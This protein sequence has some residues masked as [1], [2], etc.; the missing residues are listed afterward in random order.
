MS[1]GAICLVMYNGSVACGGKNFQGHLSTGMPDSSIKPH[2]P[3]ATLA[4][5]TV[6]SMAIAEGVACV[7]AAP[8]QGNMVYCLGV[9]ARGQLGDGK[10]KTNSVVPMPVLGLRQSP[11][12]AQLVVSKTAAC[13]LYAGPGSKSSVQCWGSRL[14]DPTPVSQAVDV[15]GVSGAASLA[16]GLSTACAVLNTGTVSC[17]RYALPMAAAEVPNLGNVVRL[18]ISDGQI[19]H[20]AIVRSVG[21]LGSLWCW[22]RDY[23]GAVIDSSTP[24]RVSGLP[25]N[26]TDVALGGAHACALV[27]NSSDGSGGD[28]FCWG[29]NDYGQLG[30]GYANETQGFAGPKFTVPMRVKGLS[31]T[32]A[33][34]R[35]NYHTCAVTT[36]RQ[37]LCWGDNTFGQ[38]A[39][40]L[41][42]K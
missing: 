36:S 40:T 42:M 29:T 20:C 38:F 11:P 22:G 26:V 30:Q 8:S 12:I 14:N 25:G 4:G 19:F 17:W 15:P 5:I 16:A 34:Y 24:L 37:V 23:A 35:G 33:L 27:D 6:S 10:S 1:S 32:R 9:G 28:V 2:T 13:V 7:L 3:A 31:R 18:A 21:E 41:L 39:V